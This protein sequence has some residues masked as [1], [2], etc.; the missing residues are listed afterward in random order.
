MKE[1]KKW[2]VEISNLKTFYSFENNFY[3]F[4]QF[5]LITAPSFLGKDRRA[6]ACDSSQSPAAGRTKTTNTFVGEKM[7][8]SH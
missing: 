7:F 3:T 6:K 8:E 1:G 4:S 2:G 5:F